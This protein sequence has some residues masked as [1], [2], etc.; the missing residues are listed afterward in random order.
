MPASRLL[1]TCDPG[2]PTESIEPI[3]SVCDGGDTALAARVMP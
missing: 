2:Q 3:T 1:S